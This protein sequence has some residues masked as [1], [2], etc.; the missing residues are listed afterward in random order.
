MKAI[1]AF[2]SLPADNEAA[3]QDVTLPDPVATG[4]DLLVEVHAVSVNPVDT[5]IRR[6]L[7]AEGQLDAKV[8]GYDASGIVRAVGPEVTLF[9]PGDRVWYAGAIN[10]PGSNSELHLVDERIVGRMPINL[11][12]AEAAALPLTAIT[13]WELLFDRLGLEF[14]AHAGQKL[15]VVGAA[16]GVGSILVQ[17]ARQLTGITV[18]ATASRPQ[19][20]E[21]VRI[22][23]AQHVVDHSGPIDAALN[24]AG[25]G[26]VDYV[27][28]LTHT[29]KHFESLVNALKPQ[30]KL[31]LID[32]PEPIDIRIM[33]RKCLSLHWELMFTRSLFTTPDIQE[34]HRLLNEVAQLVEDGRIRTTLAEHFGPINAANLRRAHAFIESGAASGKVV[35]EGFEG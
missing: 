3:L 24:A 23:G 4:H 21:W 11:G 19:T 6:G 25:L 2:A 14:G 9:R 35:L 18:I 22:L 15:L 28:S 34:Q 27:V 12:F 7:P 29:H 8:M 20:Q 13:A 31:A 16:G 5:K 10:R 1:A 33:K 32:D 26:E 17:L 30:G